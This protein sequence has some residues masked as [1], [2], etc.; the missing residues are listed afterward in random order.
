MI[1]IVCDRCGGEKETKHYVFPMLN[2]YYVQNRG[3]KLASF[4]RYEDREIDLCSECEL[5]LA[6]VITACI[7]KEKEQ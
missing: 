4:F 6:N 3:I 2:E 7:D 1:K 5:I